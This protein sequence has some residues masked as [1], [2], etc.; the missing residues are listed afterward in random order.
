[1]AVQKMNQMAD[2]EGNEEKTKEDQAVKSKAEVDDIV[3]DYK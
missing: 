2:W 1:M 3:I